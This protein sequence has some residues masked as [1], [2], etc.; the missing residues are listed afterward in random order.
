LVYC[1]GSTCVLIF[2]FFLASTGGET[3]GTQFSPFQPLKRLEIGRLIQ[4]SDKAMNEKDQIDDQKI[5]MGKIG[6]RPYW[7][8]SISIVIRALHLVGASVFLSAFLVHDGHPPAMFS[9]IVFISGAALICTEWMRHRQIFR[10]I[11][12]ASTLLKLILLGA[13]YHGLLP[14]R[15][16]VLSVFVLAALA[17]HTPKKVR[18]RLLF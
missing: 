15:E 13:A 4:R 16:T 3:I 17:S 12:G 1:F 8:L 5:R 2:A 9:R 14:A 6:P 18:H 10:E 11:S 7:V